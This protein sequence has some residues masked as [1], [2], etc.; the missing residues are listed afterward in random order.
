MGPAPLTWHSCFSPG[1]SQIRKRSGRRKERCIWKTCRTGG[2]QLSE[3]IGEKTQG[4]MVRS[5][6][7]QRQSQGGEEECTVE[8]AMEYRLCEGER[9]GAYNSQVS[10]WVLFILC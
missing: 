5:G 3:A 6:P 9:G 2:R 8:M 7:G 4:M 1:F 10:D